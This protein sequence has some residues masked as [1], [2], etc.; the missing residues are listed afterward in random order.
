VG[1]VAKGGDGGVRWLLSFVV[2]RMWVQIRGES[3]AIRG[4]DWLSK[5]LHPEGT[6]LCQVGF[7]TNLI[8]CF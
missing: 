6:D 8:I 7:I 1:N 2:V 5:K 3:D 4:M